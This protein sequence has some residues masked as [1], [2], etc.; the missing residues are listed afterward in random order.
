MEILSEE[1]ENCTASNELD[2][3]DKL[4]GG[5]PRVFATDGLNTMVWEA[6]LMINI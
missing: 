3:A 4:K 5:S 6:L 2:V 1:E